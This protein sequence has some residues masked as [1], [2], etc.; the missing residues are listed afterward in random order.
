LGLGIRF[1]KHIERTKVLIIL[2]DLLDGDFTRQYKTLLKEMKEY[3]ENLPL[4]PSLVV[5]SKQDAAGKSRENAFLST[6]IKGEKLCIS[7]FTGFNIDILKD[8][9]VLL[10]EQGNECL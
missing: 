5:G 8:K 6:G 4:K 7:S 2:I 3:S 9:I 10:V 1:L